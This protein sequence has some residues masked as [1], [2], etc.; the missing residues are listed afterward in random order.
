M[1]LKEKTCQFTLSQYLGILL[2][3]INW[4]RVSFMYTQYVPKVLKSLST[5]VCKCIG[6]SSCCTKLWKKNPTKTFRYEDSSLSEEV[7]EESL[8]GGWERV[9]GKQHYILALPLCSGQDIC[10]WPLPATGTPG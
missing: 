3:K 10:Y 9:M 2:S 5:G 4:T 6:W 7:S 1:K 8:A